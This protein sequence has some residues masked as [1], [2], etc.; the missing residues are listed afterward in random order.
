MSSM[1]TI[2]IDDLQVY[3]SDDTY[4]MPKHTIDYAIQAIDKLRKIEQLVED[5]RLKEMIAMGV[6]DEFENNLFMVLKGNCEA[7]DL[8]KVN[9]GSYEYERYNYKKEFTG[10]H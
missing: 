3:R 4:V 8:A 5:F 2:A 9:R 10:C 7:I 1:S 6:S